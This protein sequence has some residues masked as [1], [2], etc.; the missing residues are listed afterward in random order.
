MK[1]ELDTL[2]QDDLLQPPQ[3]FT[4]R[5]MHRIQ[6]L[7][8][9]RSLPAAHAKPPSPLWNLLRWIATFAGLIGG[10]ILGLSQIA[11]FVFAF[12]LTATAI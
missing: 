2:L 7:P 1:D 9:H 8:Q 3:D 10:G 5:M 12:W 4:Q 6:Q 11:G